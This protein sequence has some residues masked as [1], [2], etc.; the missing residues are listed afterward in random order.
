ML[1]LLAVPRVMLR[2]FVGLLI[3]LMFRPGGW[4]VAC[5]LALLATEY[6]VDFF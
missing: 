4:A 5:V 2:V 6:Y 1:G 3:W